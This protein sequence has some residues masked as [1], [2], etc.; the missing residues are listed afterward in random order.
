MTA[1][2][3]AVTFAGWGG[4]AQDQKLVL[5]EP[6]VANGED[7]RTPDY[8]CPQL[9]AAVGGESSDSAAVCRMLGRI[10]GL[11]LQSG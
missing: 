8:A 1:R 10:A 5:D 6:P 4:H 3:S 11:P 9:L 2:Y 7:G